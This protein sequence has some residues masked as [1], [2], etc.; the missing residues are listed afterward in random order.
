MS[1]RI[2]VALALVGTAHR[3]AAQQATAPEFAGRSPPSLLEP[4]LHPL[5]ARDGPRASAWS[6][7][8]S[9]LIPGAGQAMLGVERF[10]PYAAFET[11]SW[12]QYAAHSRASVR[13]R[14]GYRSLAARVAR[15][16]FTIVLPV[17]GWEYYERMEH[18][19]ESGVYEVVAGGVLDPEPDTTTYNGSVWLLAR[20]TYWTDVNSAPDTSAREWKLA[21]SFY[22]RRAYDQTY[23][24]SWR[25]AQLEYD[26][27]RR[28]IRRSNDSK[29]KSLQ[30]LGAVI[31]DHLLST[32][33][34]YITVRVRR[35][36]SPEPGGWQ[37]SGSLPLGGIRPR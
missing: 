27:F 24:W 29:R 34:A 25:N 14:S 3:A 36:P 10:V 12:T 8:A 2:L 19:L 30:D 33:D 16:A 5:A 21:A 18:F 15:S 6:I 28:L 26:E 23:R 20:R 31:A 35:R 37:I 4:S 22:K 1:R 32:V 11:Y 7:A 17:G 9:A 13:E